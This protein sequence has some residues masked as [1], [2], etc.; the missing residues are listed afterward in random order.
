MRR[1]HRYMVIKINDAREYLTENDGEL[2]D[3]IL[4]KV[5]Q[6]RA[7]K[8]KPPLECVVVEHDWPEYGPTWAAIA[9][10]VDGVTPNEKLSG[11]PSAGRA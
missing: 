6:G 10:R 9:A 1:E 8:G 3:R 7:K 11:P 4:D 5:A 2:L